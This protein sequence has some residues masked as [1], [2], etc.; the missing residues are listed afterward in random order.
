MCTAEQITKNMDTTMKVYSEIYELLSEL[1]KPRF[2]NIYNPN[3]NI[4]LFKSDK[5]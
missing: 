4:L 1:D 5:L 3:I 2:A